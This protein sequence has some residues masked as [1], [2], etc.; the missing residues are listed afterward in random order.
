M[1]RYGWARG[2]DI[3]A[4]FGLMLDNVAV[5]I[6]L[7]TLVSSSAPLAQQEK[8]RQIRFTPG[9]VLTRMVP[10]TA[11]GVLLGDL[12]YTVLA[13]RLARRTGR[14][15]V[16]AMPLGLDTPSTIGIPFLVLLP[17]LNEGYFHVSE[18]DHEQAMAFAWHVGVVIL[19]LVGV[20]KII[21]APLGNAVRRLVPRAGLLGS[22]AAIAL[23]LI[24]VLPLAQ[25]GIAAVPLVGMTALALILWT[26]VAHRA[27]PGRF[28]GALAAVLLGVIVYQVGRLAESAGGWPLV[29]P[30]EHVSGAVAWEP[31]AL[32]SFY[33]NHSLD[34]WERVFV[35]A[36]GK[37]PVV[38]PF[39]LATIVGGIDC[40]ESA[41]AA[42]DEFD[43]SRILLTEG[44]ASLVAG[45]LGGVIQTTPYI[46]QPA[47]KKM[48]GR[49]AYTLATALFVGGV[50]YFGGFQYLFEWLPRA[51]L[52]PI[53]VFVGLEIT[54][55]SFH[56]TP[57]R[58][59]PA[60]ALAMMPALAYLI[61]IPLNMA[62][63]VHDPDPSARSLVQTLRC[64]AGGF[65]ITSLLWAAALAMLIDG[66]LVRSALYFGLAGL[67]ALFGI[68]HSPLRN[69][70]IDL[71]GRVLAQVP[72]AFQEAIRYQT[73]YHWAGA[74]ALVVL[75]LLLLALIP[76]RQ[77]RDQEAG[78]IPGKLES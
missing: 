27:L 39:A 29:P 63:G 6:L 26:L 20:F 38:L 44:V 18:R 64:L 15:D 68:I 30:P 46:G 76:V 5:M 51:A 7:F 2:G 34:W 48:G 75:L 21:C 62:L 16:T 43:T 52:F 56:A 58:H 36:L 73:P 47:Y 40:T 66:R 11:V 49:A 31:A 24:S 55:Q 72:E 41:A 9:F 65:I 4:F 53:L 3:N 37:L 67:F 28:P 61:T 45:L 70:Q 50:G 25:E 57:T 14:E 59:Y 22:L 69:E 17:A 13:F 71:P 78:E 33:G 42:G 10:G 35:F 1:K 74:Y 77:S 23:A 8:D 54:A 12:V 32:V 60:L 19:A